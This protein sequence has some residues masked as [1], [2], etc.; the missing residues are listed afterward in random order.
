MVLKTTPMEQTLLVDS[1]P[2]LLESIITCG[3]V[4]IGALL[5]LSNCLATTELS[6]LL[7]NGGRGDHGSGLR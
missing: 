4:S 3:F 7:F 1:N 2:L 5:G 6:L